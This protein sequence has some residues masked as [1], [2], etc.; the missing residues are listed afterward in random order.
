MTVT[1]V[2]KPPSRRRSDLLATPG[3]RFLVF[4]GA[5]VAAGLSVISAL[6]L[7]DGGTKSQLVTP[8]A[9][10][11]GILLGFVAITRFKAFVLF[12]LFVRASVDITRVSG[13]SAGSTATN[14]AAKAGDPA[15]ILAL[16]LIVTSIVWLLAQYR[17][18]GSL[19]SVKVRQVLVLFFVAGLLSLLASPD[20][21]PSAVEALR[22]LAVVMMYIVAEQLSRDALTRKHLMV[23]AFASSIFPLLLTAEGFATGHPRSELKGSYTRII[24]TFTQ[25]NDFG[26]YLM[27][28]TIMGVAMYPHVP[29]RWRWPMRLLIVGWTVCCVLTYT[30]SALVGLVLGVVIIGVFQS[31][32]ILILMGVGAVVALVALPPLAARFSS[33]TKAQNV[34]VV[35]GQVVLNNNSFSWRLNYWTQILPLANRSPIIGIGLGETQ[36]ST[37]KVKQPHNDYVKAY[38]ETGLAGLVAYVLLQ[39]TLLSVTNRARKACAKGTWDYGAAVGALGCCAAFFAVSFVANVIGSI[40]NVWYLLVFV[41]VAA[42]PLLRPALSPAGTSAAAEPLAGP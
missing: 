32:R 25:S 30:R 7:I 11:F 1:G 15:T 14:G 18:E 40:V 31:K 35:N 39:L 41:A 2:E 20:P 37:S 19:P 36:Y 42:G 13:K 16:V 28:L 10:G 9:A 12:I 8:L 38:V 33:L 34:Q 4:V 29:K 23:A 6:T 27:F 21:G 5:A 26:L 17:R 24:G 3:M 22:L